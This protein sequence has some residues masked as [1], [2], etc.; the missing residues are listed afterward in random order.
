MTAARVYG[1]VLGRSTIALALA[2]GLTLGRSGE[3]RGSTAPPASPIPVAWPPG[4]SPLPEGGGP[5]GSPIGAVAIHHLGAFEPVASLDLPAGP[6]YDAPYVQRLR[7]LRSRPSVMPDAPESPAAER[8]LGVDSLVPGIA[9]PGKCSGGSND[10]QSCDEDAGCP[11]GRCRLERVEIYR[12]EATTGFSSTALPRTVLDDV[13]LGGTLPTPPAKI[14]SVEFGFVVDPSGIPGGVTMRV[15]LR[16]WNT[17]N[18]AGSP[19]NS[20]FL[21]GASLLI[22]GPLGVDTGGAF[23]ATA[24]LGPTMTITP[25]DPSIAVQID[26]R[27]DSTSTLAHATVLFVNGSGSGP[28][29]GGSQNVY[30][31]DANG[32]GQ[33]DP[34]DARSASPPGQANF[35]LHVGAEP[36]RAE[37]EPNGSQAQA[38]VIATCV[39]V[40]AALNPAGDADWYRFTFNSPRP[41]VARVSCSDPND[42]STLAL[43]DAG[44]NVIEVND[45][46]SETDRC[47]EITRSLT[48]GTYFLQVRE[49]GDDAV[50]PG[51][52]VEVCSPPAEVSGPLGVTGS[53]VTLVEWSAVQ[54]AFW[55]DVLGSSTP[56][57]ENGV[58]CLASGREYPDALEFGVP[59]PGSATFY[60][61]RADD[62]FSAGT[63]GARSDGLPRVTEACGTGRGACQN[64]LFDPI[65]PSEN[66]VGFCVGEDQ[67]GEGE[68]AARKAG[69][70]KLCQERFGAE[71]GGIDECPMIPCC[72]STR[73]PVPLRLTNCNQENVVCGVRQKI[74]KCH[75]EIPVNL[76][77]ACKCVCAD[78]C[79]Q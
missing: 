56:D 30:W 35:Y 42:D 6:G 14:D 12:N 7:A 15:E 25:T 18:T 71:C 4:A 50:L 27:D 44:G 24:I 55:Y 11:V 39:P 64:R 78:Q 45:D 2:A 5:A 77:L 63:W 13:V 33:F 52:A 16:F 54:G 70:E 29:T 67:C 37:S 65:G 31:R 34:S 57:L 8:V 28:Q 73:G 46:V 58:R 26:F 41:L 79:P 62:D 76:G 36:P 69:A 19:V 40:G 53:Q 32:N 74:C 60:L 72:A 61:V 1:S 17:L 20:D 75:Y 51:Y 49:R 66:D 9:L 48:P 21:G 3:A 43:L 47:S 68:D 38:S 59:S 23:A 10:G 22:P